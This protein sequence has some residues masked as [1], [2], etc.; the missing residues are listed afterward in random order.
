MSIRCSKP[1][2]DQPIE[3]ICRGC[4]SQL[5]SEHLVEHNLAIH[6]QLNPLVDRSNDVNDRL[7]SLDTKAMLATSY[8]ALDNWRV[9]CHQMIDDYF[10]EKTKKLDGLVGHK[11]KKCEEQLKLIQAKIIDLMREQKTT[12]EQVES[13]KIEVDHLQRDLQK[14]EANDF[15]ININRLKLDKN[16]IHFGD[17]LNMDTPSEAYRSLPRDV[18]SFP[19]LATDNTY[20]LLHRDSMLLLVDDQLAISDEVAWTRGPIFD[21]CYAA[22]I[23]Q[24]IILTEN[25]VFLLDPSR[26]KISQARSIPYQEWFSCTCSSTALYLT[27]KLYSSSLMQFTLT[28]TIEFVKRW[29]SADVCGEDESMDDIVY[30]NK[31]L[32]IMISSTTKK[33]VRFELRIAKSLQRVWTLPLYLAF[34]P[35]QSYRFCS[36]NR[37]EWMVADYHDSRLLHITRD[38]KVKST[39]AYQPTPS[40]L[41]EFSNSILAISTKKAVYLHKL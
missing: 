18:K 16:Q 33:I 8:Q 36:V 30:K 20:L 11:I 23:D 15:Q 12:H 14:I 34:D 2:C 24:F 9:Q 3:A 27:T 19:C 38:G 22:T 25:E 7:R 40:C 13:L 10:V 28:P 21:M 6:L 41:V 32:G 35:L 1:K 39:S 4:K 17:E 31:N 29:D 37:D 5:C 26:M